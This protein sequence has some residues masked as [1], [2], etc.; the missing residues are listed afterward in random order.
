MKLEVKPG[1]KIGMF[2]V[3]KEL[4][5]HRQPSGQIKRVFLFKCK[6]GKLKKMQLHTVKDNPKL[7]CGCEST[8]NRRAS[9]ITHGL[10]KGRLYKRW[11]YMK[12]RCNNKN[13]KEYH[14]YG[15]RWINVCERWGKFENFYEDMKDGFKIEL[16][17]D[18]VDNEKG[19]SKENCRW[20]SQKENSNN[21][22]MN[23]YIAYK[24]VTKTMKQWSESYDIPYKSFWYRLNAGWSVEKALTTK[25]A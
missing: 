18:R 25:V 22:R 5:R 23:R 9:A 1:D 3:I 15:D 24:G 21:T 11:G 12:T 20:I 8:K 13:N 6:C 7:S 16:T 10:S 4:D 19:Y 17:L 2:T 14:N